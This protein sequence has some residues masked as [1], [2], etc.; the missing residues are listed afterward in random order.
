MALISISTWCPGVDVNKITRPVTR[1]P[2][3][4]EMKFTSLVGDSLVYIIM[5]ADFFYK[6]RIREEDFWK[7]VIFLQFSL[8]SPLGQS[9]CPLR[10][11]V[12]KSP[13]IPLIPKKLHARF[14]KFLKV[15]KDVKNV[16]LLTHDGL[17][18]ITGNC[19]SQLSDSGDLKL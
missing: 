16:Q 15:L 7:L 18:T 9:D 17:R 4:G 11:L 19:N 1:T 5:H 10:L 13:G 6:C 3:P 8:S 14:E 12:Y 2:A